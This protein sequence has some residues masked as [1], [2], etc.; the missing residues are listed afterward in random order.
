MSEITTSEYRSRGT[1]RRGI[2]Q[3]ETLAIRPSPIGVGSP[4]ERNPAAEPPPVLS[5]DAYF[6]PGASRTLSPVRQYS[7]PKVIIRTRPQ[8]T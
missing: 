8:T 4:R 2:K 3:M 1:R 5:P 6:R 7:Q